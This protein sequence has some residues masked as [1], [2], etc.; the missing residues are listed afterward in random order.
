M[1]GYILGRYR[2]PRAGSYGSREGQFHPIPQLE[3]HIPHGSLAYSQ[4]VGF[5]EIALLGFPYIAVSVHTIININVW[6]V[7]ETATFMLTWHEPITYLKVCTL[8]LKCRLTTSGS[9]P[10]RTLR[11]TVHTIKLIKLAI[12]CYIL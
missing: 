6:N 4:N 12:H 2:I 10:S 11:F 5:N 9:T 8:N 3:S 7:G 1:R